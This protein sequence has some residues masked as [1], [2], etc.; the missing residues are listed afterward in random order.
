[1]KKI[2]LTI[3]IS[4]TVLALALSIH[5]NLKVFAQNGYI[6]EHID[7]NLQIMYNGYVFMNETVQLSGQTPSSFNLGFPY[8]YGSYLVSCDAFETDSPTH[9]FPVTLNQPLEDRSGY[10][11]IDIDFSGGTPQK[12]SVNVLFSNSLIS[13]NPQNASVYVLIFPQFP[14]LTQDI[15]SFI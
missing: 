8:I 13:Q 11:G 4:I 9:T 2:A 15:Q 7:Q 1:M 6:V 3:I 10:Y 5:A 12:F 14:S